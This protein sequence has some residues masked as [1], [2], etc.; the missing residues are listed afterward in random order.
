V[1]IDSEIPVFVEVLDSVGNPVESVTV[2]HLKF[3]SD[4]MLE[5]LYSGQ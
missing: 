5:I 4:E 1:K 2:S 3:E